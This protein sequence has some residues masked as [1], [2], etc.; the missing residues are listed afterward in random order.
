MAGVT[1]EDGLIDRL[2]YDLRQV[3][4][5]RPDGTLEAKAGPYVEPVQLQVVCQSL[6]RI[7]AMPPSSPPRTWTNSAAAA[8][9]AWTTCWPRTTPSVWPQPPR[10]AA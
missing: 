2:I 6:W 5:Q 9:R 4:V 10:R 3:K 7:K 1:Y 8:A